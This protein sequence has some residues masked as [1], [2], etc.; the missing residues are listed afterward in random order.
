MKNP[1]APEFSRPVL[2]ESLPDEGETFDIEADAL[3]RQALAKRFG[4]LSLEALTA[5]ILLTPAAGGAAASARGSLAAQ[6][7]QSCVVSLKP[8]ESRIEATFERFY[9]HRTKPGASAGIDIGPLAEEEDFPEPLRAGAIDLGEAAAEQ[10]AL[11][12]D[13]F[14]RVKDAAFAGYS[15]GGE[16]AAAAVAEGSFAALA[17]LKKKLPVK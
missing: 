13:P 17:K 7:T 16:P 5:R 11:E 12:L 8:V 2:V 1:P 14:P 9:G 4:L 10:L 3:E 15:S 6:L